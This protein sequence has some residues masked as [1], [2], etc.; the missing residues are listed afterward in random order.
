MLLFSLSK[1]VF[2]LLKDGFSE[3]GRRSFTGREIILRLRTGVS[4]LYVLIL[5]G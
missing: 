3:G 4:E 1:A 5:Y 2:Q